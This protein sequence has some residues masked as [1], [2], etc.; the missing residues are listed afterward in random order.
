MVIMKQLQVTYFA[1]HL[2]KGQAGKLAIANIEWY[3][4]QGLAEVARF[5]AATLQV[6]TWGSSKKV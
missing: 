3:N 2:R 6:L 4:W 1:S 5:L